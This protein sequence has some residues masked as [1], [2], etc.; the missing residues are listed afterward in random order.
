[1]GKNIDKEL[2]KMISRLEKLGREN[3]FTLYADVEKVE[4]LKNILEN[5]FVNS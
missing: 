2:E 3:D 1:M 4:K 5:I